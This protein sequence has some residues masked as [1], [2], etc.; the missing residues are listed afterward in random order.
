[1]VQPYECNLMDELTLKV[2][3]ARVAGVLWLTFS[4][5]HPILRVRRGK[6]EGKMPEHSLLQGELYGPLY[7]HSI[8]ILHSS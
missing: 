2:G 3:P 6:A 7:R 1:M 5:C 8:D 4:G